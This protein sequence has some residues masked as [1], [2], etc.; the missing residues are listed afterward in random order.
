[1]PF[2]SACGKKA[3]LLGLNGQPCHPVGRVAGAG[4]VFLNLLSGPGRIAG[5]LKQNLLY[6]LGLIAVFVSHRQADECIFLHEIHFH[7]YAAIA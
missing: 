7:G 1:M 5:R 6:R 4:Q 2:S 3:R